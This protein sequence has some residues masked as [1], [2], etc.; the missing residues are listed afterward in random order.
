MSLRWELLESAKTLSTALDGAPL[1]RVED[2][3]SAFVAACVTVRNAARAA[4][5]A[6][7]G[8]DNPGHQQAADRGGRQRD[9]RHRRADGSARQIS[10]WSGLPTASGSAARDDIPAAG[11]R[12]D[13]SPRLR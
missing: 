7:T 9:L 8:E 11:G 1:E 2:P 3:D 6:L 5:S 12:A 4:V 13:V 10:T